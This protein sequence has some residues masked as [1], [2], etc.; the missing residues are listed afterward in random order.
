MDLEKVFRSHQRETAMFYLVEHAPGEVAG[1]FGAPPA[2]REAR[3]K[4]LGVLLA[5]ANPP[6]H[7][8][9]NYNQFDENVDAARLRGEVDAY[10]RKDFLTP[11]TGISEAFFPLETAVES[12]RFIVALACLDVA[13]GLELTVETAWIRRL[14]AVLCARVDYALE[15]L[16]KRVRVRDEYDASAWAD[17]LRAEIGRGFSR[18]VTFYLA[19]SAAVWMLPQDMKVN[20]RAPGYL[21][22]PAV[23]VLFGLRPSTIGKAK[24]DLVDRLNTAVPPRTRA[25]TNP[26]NQ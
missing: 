8:R 14:W 3:E 13:T 26:G 19:R 17:F 22:G 23:G 6:R 11:N 25:A 12:M 16:S 15:R 18:D 9:R 10:V 20:Q 5:A 21:S 1:K 7:R 2:L 4:V 24:F